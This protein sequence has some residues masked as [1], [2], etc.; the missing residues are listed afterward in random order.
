M[1]KLVSPITIY[2]DVYDA[3]FIV[4]CEFDLRSQTATLYLAPVQSDAEGI[5]LGRKEMAGETVL[6]RF[7]EMIRTV[8]LQQN[9]INPD[10]GIEGLLSAF[11]TFLESIEQAVVITQTEPGGLATTTHQI[12]MTQWALNST[13]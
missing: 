11:A 3:L 5:Y 13:Y 10:P 7:P 4:R 9:L 12:G 2:P 8:T 6:Y 1:I